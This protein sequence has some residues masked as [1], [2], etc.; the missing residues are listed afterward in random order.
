MN[1]VEGELD[2]EHEDGT[3]GDVTPFGRRAPRISQ[4]DVFQAADALL[5]EGHRPTIGCACDSVEAPP[6]PSTTTSTSGGRSSVLA[7]ATCRGRNFPVYPSAWRTPCSSSG[8]RRWTEHRQ[9]CATLSPNASRHSPN[10]SKRCKP[11][12]ELAEGERT[13]AARAAALEESLTIAREQLLAANQRAQSLEG[14]VQEWDRECQR[15][16]ARVDILETSGSDVRAKLDAAIAAHQ[17]ERA[18]LQDRYAAADAR[19]LLEVDR[20]RQQARQVAKEHEQQTRD[21]RRRFEALTRECD[22]LRQNLLEA[23]ADLKTAAAVREQLEARLRAAERAVTERAS[24][25]PATSKQANPSK[26]PRRPT[27]RRRRRASDAETSE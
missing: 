12:R 17:A 25:A 13:S 23:R 1:T 19:W 16:R 27:N 2:V 22:G 8:A 3:A 18:Q 24:M 11:A 9:R 5:V 6:T 7:C 4:A 20:A 26:P 15:L 10:W 21:L 14:G